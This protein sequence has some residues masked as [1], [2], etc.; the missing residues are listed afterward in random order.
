[1]KKIVS[2]ALALVL[3][4]AL[5]ATA[6]AVD[7]DNSSQTVGATYVPGNNVNAGNIHHIVLGWTGIEN[8]IYTDGDTTYTWNSTSHQYEKGTKGNGTWSTVSFSVTVTNHSNI[9]ITATADYVD[10]DGGPVTTAEWGTKSVTCGSA[11]DG[12][13]FTNTTATGAA[14]SGTISGTVKVTSGTIAE[15]TAKVGTISITID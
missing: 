5:S 13:D 7:V 4:F 1:M 12:I 8:L 9:G 11:A 10:A 14:T 6:L 3:V 2:F 15:S